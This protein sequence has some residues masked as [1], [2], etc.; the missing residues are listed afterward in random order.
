MEYSIDDK[1]EIIMKMLHY[2]IVEK[3]YNPII[4]Q[5]AENE[6]WLENLSSDDYKIVRIVSDRIINEEQFD[7]DL[8]KTKRVVSKIKQKTFSL[9][10][11]VLSIFTNMDNRVKVENKNKNISFVSLSSDEDL[12]KSDVIKN[13]F[14]DMPKKLSFNEKGA[15]LFMKITSDINKKN[16]KDAER[17][18]NVFKSKETIITKILIAINVS[19]FLLFLF[20]S[21][22]MS[23]YLG[24]NSIAIF[25]YHEYW[26]LFTSMFAHANLLHLLVNM[27]SLHIIGSQIENYMGKIR[28]L[29]IYLFS[30]ILG[31]LL[32]VA[33][34]DLNILS[35]GASGAI[36]GLMGSL[37]YFGYHYRVYLSNAL[38]SQIIPLIMVNLL[39]GFMIEGIDNFAHIGGLIGGISA[40]MAVGVQYKTSTIEKINGFV[41]SLILAIF[42]IYLAVMRLNS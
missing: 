19:L 9:K 12:N 32:S 33:M 18:N 22:N 5:G 25:Q 30:G 2:F 1:N 13:N 42:F 39:F 28:F 36:F 20:S 21:Y 34:N 3:D 37:L 7:Y 6:I 35:V 29:V 23:A 26:R 15:Q 14:P 16:K 38:K 8:F 4:L 24:A 40:A 11:P 31:S 17:V 27:Y 10:L 41:I